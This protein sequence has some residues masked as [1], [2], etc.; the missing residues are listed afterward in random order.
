MELFMTIET[1]V[2]AENLSDIL[3]QTKKELLF[4]TDREAN[5]ENVD[6]YGTEFRCI[7]VIPTCL[8]DGFWNASG[9]KERKQ[10]WRKKKE[11]DIRLRMDYDRFV[12]ETPENQRLMFIDIIVKSIQ[13]VQERSKGDFRGRELIADILKALGVTMEQLNHLNQGTTR[14]DI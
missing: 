8:D 3:R 7:A 13:V 10:I 5:L 4:I 14:T 2:G 6:N 12:R 1:Q 9:W 11:A